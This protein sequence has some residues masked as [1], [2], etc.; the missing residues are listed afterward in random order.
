MPVAANVL[1][2]QFNPVA[3]DTAYASDITCISAL[4]L[5]AFIWRSISVRLPDHRLAMAPNMSATLVCDALSMAI[6]QR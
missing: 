2:W 4:A 5:V 6:Q 3:P 1:N